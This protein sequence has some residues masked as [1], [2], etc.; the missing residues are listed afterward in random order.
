M[1]KY[2]IDES[3]SDCYKYEEKNAIKSR[4]SAKFRPVKTIGI[5]F[6]ATES[7]YLRD[8]VDVIYSLRE[9]FAVFARN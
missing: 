2:K 7:I 9:K 4:A 5:V 3:L 8:K 6:K 1:S